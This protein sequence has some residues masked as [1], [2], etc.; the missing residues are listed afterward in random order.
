MPFSPI[1][2]GVYPSVTSLRAKDLADRGIRLVLADLDNTLVP[3]KV[4]QPPQAIVDWKEELE[5]AGIQLFLLSN[6]RKPG[7]A[8][9]FAEKLGIPYQGHSG[10]PK[11]A[12]YLRAMERMGCTPKETV[13]VGDQIFTD[14]LGA[15]NAGVTPLLV[16][17]I[18]LAGN[19]ARYVRYAI[20]T[21]FRLL[22]KGRPFL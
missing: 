16:E 17:P 8:K 7:R 6:S 14:T 3:Y 18:R 2:R 21:P 19:P 1:P 20:E 15:N 13:M 5:A 22:G 12:G 9:N 11:K 4:T 10:K